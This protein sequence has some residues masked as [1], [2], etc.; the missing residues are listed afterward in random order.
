MEIK[1]DRDPQKDI[2]EKVH[3]KKY[4]AT[5]KFITN[6][7]NFSAKY[8]FFPGMVQILLSILETNEMIV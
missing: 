5:T 2:F 1:S 6:L 7:N 8:P 4:S 3:L